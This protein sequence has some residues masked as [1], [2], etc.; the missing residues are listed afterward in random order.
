MTAPEVEAVA[1][2]VDERC[3]ECFGR[4]LCTVWKSGRFQTAVQSC[5]KDKPRCHKRAVIATHMVVDR[6][7][8]DALDDARPPTAR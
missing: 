2:E 3:R 7:D 6:W 5:C 1:R 8:N 4:L